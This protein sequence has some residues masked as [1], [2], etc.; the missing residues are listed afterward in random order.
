MFNKQD[1]AK[2]AAVAVLGVALSKAITYIVVDR[3]NRSKEELTSKLL[4]SVSCIM[5]AHHLEP[6]LKKLVDRQ[7]SRESA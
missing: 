5:L 3:S 1:L 4:I 2:K 7:L 6:Q